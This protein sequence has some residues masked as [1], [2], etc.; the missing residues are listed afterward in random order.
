MGAH[1]PLR[2]VFH[3]H[4]SALFVNVH[5]YCIGSAA[6]LAILDIHLIITRR[7]VDE[8]LIDLEAPGAA[9]RFPHG[10]T[11]Y[12]FMMSVGGK[13]CPRG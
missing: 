5:V 10:G 4:D 13:V 9:K 7:D 1:L 3:C 12:L 2:L 8:D 6:Y 11:P